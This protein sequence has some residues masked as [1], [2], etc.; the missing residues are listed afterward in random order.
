[1]TRY[2]QAEA[3]TKTQKAAVAFANT[4]G[5]E[6]EPAAV[7]AAKTRTFLGHCRG[8]VAESSNLPSFEIES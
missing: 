3:A 1:M 4:P 5:L 2:V 7:G 6:I 8:L